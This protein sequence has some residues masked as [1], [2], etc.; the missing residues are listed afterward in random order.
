M[1]MYMLSTCSWCI[2]LV[3]LAVLSNGFTVRIAVYH[4]WYVDHCC[5]V[6]HSITTIHFNNSIEEDEFVRLVDLMMRGNPHEGPVI[7]E[8]GEYCSTSVWQALLRTESCGVV[9]LASTK[10]DTTAN[11]TATSSVADGE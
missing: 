6:T 2:P 7:S 5:C 11:T 9:S 1:E 8:A 3:L 4:I 10:D